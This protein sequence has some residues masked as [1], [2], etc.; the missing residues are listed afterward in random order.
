MMKTLAFFLISHIFDFYIS[1]TFWWLRKL[2]KALLGQ[3]I[4]EKR[5]VITD[6]A[7][8]DSVTW[9]DSGKESTFEAI[10]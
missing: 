2:C 7:L 9:G 8:I 1:C 5:S 10:N 4:F 3:R 6:H